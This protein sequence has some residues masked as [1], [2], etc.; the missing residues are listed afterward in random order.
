MEFCWQQPGIVTV[1]NDT[2]AKKHLMTCLSGIIFYTL[3]QMA[4]EWHI[5]VC[6]S[7]YFWQFTVSCLT[8]LLLEH[9][10]HLHSPPSYGQTPPSHPSICPSTHLSFTLREFLPAQ[11][12]STPTPL[13]TL[14]DSSSLFL[15][16]L[17][18]ALSC[19]CTPLLRRQLLPCQV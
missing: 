17:S 6:V 5:H 19:T 13:F 9:L 18:L 7:T 14:S 4:L 12:N 15:V 3:K 10:P 8:V 2:V 16:S 11:K 1:M